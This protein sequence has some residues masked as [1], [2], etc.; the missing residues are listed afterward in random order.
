MRW[1]V[2]RLLLIELENG[3]NF[4]RIYREW[5]DKI[6]NQNEQGS[7]LKYLEGVEMN[8]FWIGFTK[9]TDDTPLNDGR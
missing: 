3:S 5:F 1:I 9:W 8:D 7:F 4:R 6:S 2:P